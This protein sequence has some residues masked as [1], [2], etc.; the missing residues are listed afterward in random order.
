[1]QIQ[2]NR[3]GI[4]S[5]IYI[6]A[7]FLLSAISLNGDLRGSRIL[8]WTTVAIFMFL[9][10]VTQ[11]TH[12]KFNLTYTAWILGFAFI[13]F[14]SIGWALSASLV[15]TEMKT[16]V[17]HIVV[18]SLLSAAIKTQNDITTLLKIIL[19][20]CLFNASYI[21]AKNPD[22]I[23]SASEGIG[24]RL[25]SNENWNANLIG[26]MCA[27]GTVIILHFILHQKKKSK[28][29]IVILLILFIFLTFVAFITGSRKA[30]LAVLLGVFLYLLLKFKKH[31]IR[32]LLFFAIF[33]FIAFFLIY[34]VPFLYN[35]IGWRMEAFLASFS[36]KGEVDHS[37]I[38][39]DQLGE[40]ATNAWKEKPLLGWGTDCVR[41]I[42]QEQ[43]GHRLYS[44]NNYKE[45]L[46]NLGVVGFTSFYWGYVYCVFH[47]WKLRQN[48]FAK[49]FLTLILVIL[50]LGVGCV[51][52]NDFLFGLVTMLAFSCIKITRVSDDCTQHNSKSTHARSGL[53]QN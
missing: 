40:V 15:L 1:M 26:M 35:I 45:L 38:L 43:I 28:I 34:N 36:G 32:I 20:A 2:K 33:A 46:A 14:A 13:S 10:L 21:L 50:V 39:R 29:Q 23:T 12:I 5:P 48:D 11:T 53:C 9:S 37:T 16:M 42:S 47:L 51:H 52:Y 8:W 19:A 17:V 7:I 18:F 31:R 24:E 3:S 4:T 25:G 22:L 49:L 27:L 44:H 41:L 6:C 30:F